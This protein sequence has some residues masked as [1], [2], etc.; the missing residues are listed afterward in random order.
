MTTILIQGMNS[1]KLVTMGYGETSVTGGDSARYY[2]KTIGKKDNRQLLEKIKVLLE[3][4]RG[5]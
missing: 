1:A 5:N 2:Y 3:A 4:I